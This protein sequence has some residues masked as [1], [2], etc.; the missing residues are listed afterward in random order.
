MAEQIERYGVTLKTLE[1][2]RIGAPQDVMEGVDN[3]I[4]A[5][6]GRAAVLGPTLKGAL[7]ANVEKYLIET[8]ASDGDMKPCIPS[9]EGTLSEEEK[10]LISKGTYRPGGSCLF[11]RRNKSNSICP[12]CYLLGAQ[13][14]VGFV[15]VPFLLTDMTPEELY[16]VRIDRATG[17]VS[18][19]TNREYQILPQGTEFKGTLEVVLQDP[20]KSW[21]LGKNRETVEGDN[22]QGDKWLKKGGWT[23][24]KV[25]KE[26]LLDRLQTITLLGGFK[27]KGCGKVSI[28]VQAM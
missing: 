25:K 15:R 16:S 18:E 28:Q 21:E 3:P 2:F 24:E 13:G 22:C 14:L 4:A 26:L 19:R 23:Q 20:V 6:G 7:R 11:S 17:V 10:K 8:Y 27:S 5:I 12:A 9:S 1:P